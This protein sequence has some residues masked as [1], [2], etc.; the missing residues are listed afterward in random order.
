M[1]ESEREEGGM[2]FVVVAACYVFLHPPWRPQ[3][4]DSHCDRF[5]T[6]YP[7]IAELNLI[8]TQFGGVQLLLLLS[9]I[10]IL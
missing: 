7:A 6:V 8:A 2:V 10:H 1:K 4:R 9:V 3:V 5:C